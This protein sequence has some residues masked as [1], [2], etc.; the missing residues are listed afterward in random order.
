[1][2]R[3]IHATARRR[4]LF[5]SLTEAPIGSLHQTFGGYST[6]KVMNTPVLLL[7]ATREGQSRRIAEHLAATVRSRGLTA[8]VT[9]VAQLPQGFSLSAHSAAIITAS[10]HLGKHEPEMVE[11]VKLH[12]AELERMPTMFLSVSLAEAGAEDMT[13]EFEERM[14]AAMD[15]QGMMDAFLAETGWHPSKILAVAG[16]L[17]YTKYNFL[18][19]LVIK[20]IAR[21][22]GES[23]DTSRDHELTDWAALDH[24]VDELLAGIAK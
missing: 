20:R 9:G 19:R 16:A 11:F 8:E 23:T 1:M 6:L 7:Y 2:A 3:T 10:V 21:L 17:M 15:V 4:T 14:K 22:Q 13:A 5:N 18:V 12:R 24:L